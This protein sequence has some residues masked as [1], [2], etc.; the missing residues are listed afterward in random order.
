LA[1]GSIALAPRKEE[2]LASHVF[3]TLVS[4]KSKKAKKGGQV[5]QNSNENTIDF[6]IIKKFNSLNLS[7]PIKDEDYAKTITELDQLRDALIYWGKIIQRQTRIKYIRNSLKLSKEDEFKQQAEED[8]K[9][10]EQEKAKYQGEDASKQ[11]LNA[12]KLKIAQA[13]DRE[14]RLNRM[15]ADEDDDEDG[16][17][18][19]GSDDKYRRKQ[20]RSQKQSNASKKPV[21]EK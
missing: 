20:D 3:N 19:I 18:E 17:E 8:E 15:W 7:V 13:I 21:K 14:S 5:Q 16:E 1:K 4:K 2:K 11:E 12:D 10:I 6:Q 9:Y